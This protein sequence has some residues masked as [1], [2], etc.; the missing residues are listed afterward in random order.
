MITKQKIRNAVE[1]WGNP[2]TLESAQKTMARFLRGHLAW[3]PP[4]HIPETREEL[5]EASEGFIVE[6][7]TSEIL[8][9]INEAG[10]F[11]FDSQKG[12]I[13]RGTSKKTGDRYVIEQREYVSVIVRKDI[14]RPL[15][16][17]LRDI[18]ARFAFGQ[19][20]KQDAI[21]LTR[22]NGEPVTFGVNVRAGKMAD[23]L[24]GFSYETEQVLSDELIE[25][26]QYECQTVLVASPE[27]GRSFLFNSLARSLRA[28]S[29]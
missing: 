12:L 10:L 14:V 29:R 17:E 7:D 23:Y 1:S 5:K 19:V 21:V 6:S 18:D 9:E 28:I 26:I 20:L 13:E 16:S 2:R 8:A 24:A 11:T 15:A 25:D 4:S 27:F 3:A 22:Q